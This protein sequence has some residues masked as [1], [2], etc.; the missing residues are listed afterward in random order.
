MCNRAGKSGLKCVVL[1]K[2]A[3]KQCVV[4]P[5]KGRFQMEPDKDVWKTVSLL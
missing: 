1:K 3:Q 4:G 5:E 2:I